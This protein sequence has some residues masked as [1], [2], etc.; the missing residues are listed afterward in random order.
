MAGL[1]S[2]F[3]LSRIAI[4]VLLLL[5]AAILVILNSLYDILRWA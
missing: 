3:R 2:R 5:A 4:A 1:H